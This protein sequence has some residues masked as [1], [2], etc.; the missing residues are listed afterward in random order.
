M[1]IGVANGD[2]R[3]ELDGGGLCFSFRALSALESP[4]SSTRF[5]RPIFIAK[6]EENERVVEIAARELA[7]PWRNG[8]FGV[9]PLERIWKWAWEAAPNRQM[10]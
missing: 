6:R 4:Y 2:G 3:L 7:K 5:P 9:S 8:F 1:V 10:D